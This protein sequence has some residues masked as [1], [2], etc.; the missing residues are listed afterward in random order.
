[1]VAGSANLAKPPVQDCPLG[2]RRVTPR[3]CVAHEQPYPVSVS[4]YVDADYDHGSAPTTGH[5][6]SCSHFACQSVGGHRI[7]PFMFATAARRALSAAA[8]TS[9]R[10]SACRIRTSVGVDTS[11]ASH[12]RP[13]CSGA[14]CVR[15]TRRL[16]RR[17]IHRQGRSRCAPQGQCRS[18][19]PLPTSARRSR[20]TCSCRSRPVS[21]HRTGT[22]VGQPPPPPR[23]SAASLAGGAS[24]AS[25]AAWALS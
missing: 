3:A 18:S 5:F 8:S 9:A 16:R 6:A 15:S 17:A 4:A 22:G 2:L 1:M 21:R 23:R 20:R 19:A 11:N 13:R 24:S 14:P 25:R 7:V 10:F 12:S